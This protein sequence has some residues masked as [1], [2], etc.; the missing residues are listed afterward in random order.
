MWRIWFRFRK[1]YRVKLGVSK[2][3]DKSLIITA[4]QVCAAI[5]AIIIIISFLSV[6]QVFFP[7]RNREPFSEFGVLGSNMKLGDYPSQIVASE[8]VNLYGYVGNQMG[9]PMFYT[10]MVK[11]GD[12]TTVINPVKAAAIQQYSQVLSFNQTWIFPVS[13]TLTHIGNNQRLIFELWYYNETQGQMQYPG[14]WG[15]VWVNVTAPAV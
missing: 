1:N 15:Q 3:T 12:N 5:L 13:V 6:Y 4:Q 11:L 7:Q 14:E 8:T 10:V 2:E 9:K